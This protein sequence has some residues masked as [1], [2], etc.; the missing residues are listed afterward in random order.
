MILP[1]EVPSNRTAAT[2]SRYIQTG[3]LFLVGAAAVILLHLPELMAAPRHNPVT[4]VL[5]HLF[6]LGFGTLITFGVL[7]QMIQVITGQPIEA[8]HHK[9]TAYALLVPGIL[10]QT[11]GFA[12]W[13]PWVITVGG[14][15]VVAGTFL[16]AVPFLAPLAKH[17]RNDRTALFIL[18][19]LFFLMGTVL[20]GL[21]M[22][23]Q[24]EKVWSSWLFLNGFIAHMLLGGLGW[25]TGITIGVSYK[26][27]PMFT[28]SANLPDERVRRVFLLYNGG[29]VILLTG[30]ALSWPSVGLLGAGGVLAA[31]VLYG[32]DVRTMLQRRLRKHLG[33]GMRQSLLAV[34]HLVLA[35]LLFAGLLAGW[36]AGAPWVATA[37]AQRLLVAAGMLFALGWI[38]SMIAGMLAKIAPMLVWLQVYADRAGDPNLPTIGDMIDEQAVGIGGWA[39]QAGVVLVA[40]AI[41]AGSQLL[42]LAGAAILLFG[43]VLLALTFFWVWAPTDVPQPAS[44]PGAPETR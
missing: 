5:A 37:A 11:A 2:A 30:A 7:G 14:A 40:G 33:A 9:E 6:F 3:L 28:T 32:L 38:G 35:T 41:A 15:L 34:G 17:R 44:A 12:V 42:G 25:F 13:M 43:V 29:L 39:Y 10:V 22:A 1:T 16:F 27:I 19:A 8:G 31:I 21:L 20:F 24:L 18:F 36:A 26:L 4:L 23:L